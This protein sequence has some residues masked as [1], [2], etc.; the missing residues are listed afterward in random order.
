[1]FL[2]I[3]GA[4]YIVLSE[5]GSRVFMRRLLATVESGV[6]QQFNGCLVNG[7]VATIR[8]WKFS[9][10]GVVQYMQRVCGGCDRHYT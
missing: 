1:M 7:F 2:R 9:I 6:V 4:G 5:R 10:Q 8:M 3:L